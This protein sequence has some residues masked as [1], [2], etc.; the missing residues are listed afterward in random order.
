MSLIYTHEERTPMDEYRSLLRP[1]SLR[2]NRL[3]A[4]YFRYEAWILAGWILLA[5]V[6]AW[7]MR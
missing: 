2:F 1:R 5:G 6:L 7:G 3:K 4:V